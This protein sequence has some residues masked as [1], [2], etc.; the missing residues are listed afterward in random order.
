MEGTSLVS[1][2]IQTCSQIADL[3]FSQATRL[4]H[5]TCEFVSLRSAQTWLSSSE[6]QCSLRSTRTLR[7]QTVQTNRMHKLHKT[8]TKRVP[9]INTPIHKNLRHVRV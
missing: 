2:S 1:C 4:L 9:Y 7:G 5:D 3:N 6:I 8:N